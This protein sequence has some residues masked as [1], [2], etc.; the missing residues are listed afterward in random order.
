MRKDY[1]PH[2]WESVNYPFCNSGSRKHYENF[3]PKLQYT[4]VKCLECG[5][6]HQNPRAKYDET[7]LRDAYGLYEGYIPEYT[8]RED[9]MKGWG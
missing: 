4:Y 9:V 1:T 5:L 8:F 2:A 6:I 3:G 7:F